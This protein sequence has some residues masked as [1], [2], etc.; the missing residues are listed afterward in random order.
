M[1]STSSSLRGASRGVSGASGRVVSTT[2]SWV[3]SGDG[4]V[5]VVVSSGGRAVVVVA[6]TSVVVVPVSVG[7]GSS[8]TEGSTGVGSDI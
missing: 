5:V 3:V 2:G 4:S 6:S 8:G 7:S 1:F